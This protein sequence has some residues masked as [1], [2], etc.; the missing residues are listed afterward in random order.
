MTHQLT[1]PLIDSVRGV[2][3]T[4]AHTDCPAPQPQSARH[5]A[6][7]EHVVGMIHITGGIQAEVAVV[8]PQA[9]GLRLAQRMT[10][11][12]D[13]PN[14]GIDDA[15]GELCNMIVGSAKSSLEV[16]NTAIS[17]P[18]VTRS[19]TL[20]GLPADNEPDGITLAFESEAGPFTVV[21]YAAA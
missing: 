11:Q 4:M 9:T 13:M 18:H 21:L 10:G 20:D 16:S 12:D 17:C 7:G 6:P 1:Q 5:A 2:M 14:D 19:V 3:A 8:F 15:L